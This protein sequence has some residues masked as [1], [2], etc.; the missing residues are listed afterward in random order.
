MEILA[1][2]AL[3]AEKKSVAVVEVLMEVALQGVEFLVEAVVEVLVGV[4]VSVSAV[5]EVPVEVALPGVEVPME[6]V[7]KVPELAMDL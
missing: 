4:E 6:V 3:F 7:V 5:V 1:E 2:V